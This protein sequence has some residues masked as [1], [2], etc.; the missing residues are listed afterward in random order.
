MPIW[1]RAF[2]SFTLLVSSVAIVAQ[3]IPGVTLERNVNMKT[4]DGI[5]LVADVYRPADGQKH[6]VLLTRTPY[7]KDHAAPMGMLGAQR[8]FIIVTQ[9]TRGS[10]VGSSLPEHP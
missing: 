6:P 8:G 5:T 10:V 2:L 7:N 4:R 9:D 3:S 1:K